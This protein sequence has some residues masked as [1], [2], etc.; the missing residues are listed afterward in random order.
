MLWLTDLPSWI[1]FVLIIGVA[2]AIAI[3]ATLFAR[4]WYLRRGVTA[5]PAV[6]SAWATTLGALVAVLC[7]FTIITLWSIFAKAQADTDSEAAAVRLVAYEI[8][9]AQFPLLRAYVNHSI[10]EWP[11]MCGGKK[12]PRVVASLIALQGMAKPRAPEYASDL[13]H[14]LGELED[15]RYQRWQISNASTPDELKIA[16]CITAIALFG[17]LAIALPD[18]LD[19]HLAL[20][21]LTAT[22][23]GS[24]FW[25]MVVLSYPYCGSYFIGPDQI[26]TAA[27]ASN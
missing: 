1:A 25:V 27:R 9:P 21:V 4:R 7:A 24:V 6:A 5:G 8:S 15:A 10:R 3:G 13:H 2:N 19:T 23:L 14:Q 16:L 17:V 22:A 12:D 26:V 18:R 11:Q 20:N